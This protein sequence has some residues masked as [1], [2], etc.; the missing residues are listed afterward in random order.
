[1]KIP[2]LEPSRQTSCESLFYKDFTKAWVRNT[3]TWILTIQRQATYPIL[4]TIT[5][6]VQIQTRT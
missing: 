3:P 2:S 5:T 1:M 6:T 4:P